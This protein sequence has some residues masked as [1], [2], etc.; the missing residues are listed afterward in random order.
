VDVGGGNGALLTDILK[1][2]PNLRGIVFDLPHVA[3]KARN[4]IAEED[5]NPAVRR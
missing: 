2:N 4:K 1:A 3:D 5:C